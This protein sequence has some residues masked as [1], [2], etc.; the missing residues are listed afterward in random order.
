[1]IGLLVTGALPGTGVAQDTPVPATEDRLRAFAQEVPGQCGHVS[2]APPAQECPHFSDQLPIYA[3][4]VKDDDVTEQELATHFHSMQFGPGTD[5]ESEYSPIEG[6]TVYRDTLGVPHIYA[7]SLIN[8]SHALGYVSAEDRLFEMDVFRHA[9]RGT[10][11]ELVGDDAEDTYLKMDIATRREGYTEEEVQKMFDDFDDKFGALGKQVQDG[12]TAYAAGVNQY[13]QE[14]TMDPR[15][16]PVEYGATFT[17]PEDWTVTDT[18][19]LVVLQLRVFG[20]TAGGELQNAGLYAHL[21]E[22]LGVKLGRK[23]YN[24]LVFQNDRS[25]PTSL[26]PADANFRTQATGRPNFASVAIPDK[27][28]EVATRVANEEAARD[29]FLASLGFKA[30]ASNALLVSAKESATGNPL[31]IGAPQVGYA[32]PGFFMEVDV[33]A[34]GVDFRGPAVPGASALIPLGRGRDYAW[35]L[36]TGYSDA[37]DTRAEKLCNPEGEARP[38]LESNGYMFKGECREME[39]REETFTTKPTPSNPGPPEEETHTFYRTV[40]GPV[41][42]RTLVNGQ[43]AAFVKERFFWKREVDSVP[44]FLKWNT[45]VDS[46]DD[47]ASAARDFTMSFNAFYADANNIGYYH[48]GFYPKRAR[49]VHPSL[50]TWGT[51]RWEWKGRR[52][53][54]QQ[55]HLL[56]P[57]KG[58]VTNWN[59][60]PARGWNSHDGIKWGSIQRAQLLEDKMRRL[61]AGAGKASLS[62]LV[63]VIRESATQD[64][65]GLYL[66]PKML[67]M[68]GRGG[69]ENYKQAVGLVRAWV[70]KGA[71]RANKDDDDNMDDG[72]A[73]AIFDEWYDQLTH[74][75]FDDEL[76]ADAYPLIGAPVTDYSPEGG[77]SFWFDFSS[78]L[79]NA[80][81]PA[82]RRRMALNYC[83]NRGTKGR[84]ETCASLVVE[85]LNKAIAKLTEEQ[86]ADMTAWVTPREDIT[87]QAFGYGSVDPIPWQNRGTHN[88][89]VEILSDAGPLEPQPGPTGEPTPT[90]TPTG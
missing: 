58:W 31:Q 35:S 82:T 56:N 77:S 70:N 64:T 30:P 62:D 3:G 13:I 45:R 10:L 59:N 69:D 11:T 88:H 38:T 74:L 48:V 7:D 34:P 87:F 25:S 33:H 12:L 68:A 28:E 4:L 20:E 6:V 86:G 90:P 29:S 24:D 19:F 67:R 57:D 14:A 40:H 43:P 22:K 2:T 26:A 1:L 50:P 63:D 66:G 73:L 65:R 76:G 36:T 49:G 55:P 42:Q 79:K 71:H 44:Q 47:F 46:V 52:P 80:F 18:L 15:K 8:A 32:V 84:T 27:A 53:F 41:F 37:V 81:N 5:I 9:A 51:G 83:N 17:V 39:S 72:A 23:V 78:Y 61:L 75:V 54:T 16:M 85:A 21:V 60:K 89:V